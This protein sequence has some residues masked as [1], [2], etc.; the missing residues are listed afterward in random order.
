MLPEEDSISSPFEDDVADAWH[1]EIARRLQ[2]IDSGEV[3]LIP[4]EEVER[5][6]WSKVRP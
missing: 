5:R 1:R 3:D 6:L 2:Q 4:W